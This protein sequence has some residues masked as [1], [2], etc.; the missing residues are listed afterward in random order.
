MVPHFAKPHAEIQGFSTIN[1]KA[2][3]LLSRAIWRIPF[4]AGRPN[5][6]YDAHSWGAQHSFRGVNHPRGTSESGTS[7]RWRGSLSDSAISH[8]LAPGRSIAKTAGPRQSQVV[9]KVCSKRMLNTIALIGPFEI[10]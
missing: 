2:E 9:S 6:K 4:H 5:S 7:M 10:Q 1:A 8:Q 3:T